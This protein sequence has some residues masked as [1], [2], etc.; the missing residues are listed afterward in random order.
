[1]IESGYRD[2]TLPS[3]ASDCPY[4]KQDMLFSM[5]NMTDSSQ[6]KQFPI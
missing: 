5:Q 3:I 6:S 4:N 1:M 2:M